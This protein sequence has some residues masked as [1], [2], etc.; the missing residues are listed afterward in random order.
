MSIPYYWL[1]S[2][3]NPQGHCWG[4]IWHFLSAIN[5]TLVD[6]ANCQDMWV[7]DSSLHEGLPGPDGYPSGPGTL[8]WLSGDQLYSRLDDKMKLLELKDNLMKLVFLQVGSPLCEMDANPVLQDKGTAQQLSVILVLFL[9]FIWWMEGNVRLYQK[10]PVIFMQTHW[11]FQSFGFHDYATNGCVC[12]ICRSS[13]NCF[14][15]FLLELENIH[16]QN[17]TWTFPK[18]YSKYLP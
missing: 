6:N 2:C 1:V 17:G 7:W 12:M 11:R 13:S 9:A 14:R 3:L 5:T 16:F 15:R 8:S 18:I 4:Q 10:L